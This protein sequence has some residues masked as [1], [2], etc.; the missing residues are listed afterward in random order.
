MTCAR[1]TAIAI[2]S[3][4]LAGLLGGTA[5]AQTRPTDDMEVVR[6][7]LRADKRLVVATVLQLTEGEAQAFWP[8]YNAYQSDM[9]TH[10]DRLLKLIE[11]FAGSYESITDEAAMKM[12]NDYLALERDHVSILNGYV[13]RFRKVLPA[14]KVA[15][16]YQV[17]NKARAIVNYDLARSIPFVK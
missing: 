6:E 7:K 3:L 13:P 4:L 16:L 9:V 15:Q 5:E 2:G 11:T 12:L 14:K 10:Y 8:V 17:E 1:R